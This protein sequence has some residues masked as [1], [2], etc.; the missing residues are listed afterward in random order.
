MDARINGYCSRKDIVYT[1][2]AED[3]TFSSNNRMLL[4]KVEKFIKYIVKDE[5]FVIN[6]KKTRYLSNDVKKTVTGI[7]INGDSIHVDKKF[8]RNLRAQIY[9]SIKS[10]DYGNNSQILGKIAYVNSIEDGF[11]N[12][13][14]KYIT[15]IIT[16]PELAGD[17]NIVDAFNRNKLF[18]ELPDMVL[19]QVDDNPFFSEK[20]YW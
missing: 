16:K 3:L 13:M 20:D 17:Q 6:E 15:D 11:R 5:G 10:K 19:V 7:T 9:Q 4:N 8:K 18:S 2:Y 12:K 1:R 14:V